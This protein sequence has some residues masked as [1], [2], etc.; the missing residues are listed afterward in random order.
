MKRLFL[1]VLCTAMLLQSIGCAAAAE[2]VTADGAENSAEEYVSAAEESVTEDSF[3]PIAG[4]A[5]E[6]NTLLAE[7]AEA[8]ERVINPKT[9]LYA[10]DCNTAGEYGFL[11]TDNVNALKGYNTEKGSVL[12]LSALSGGEYGAISYETGSV[13]DVWDGTS[14]TSWYGDGTADSY[15]ITSAAALAGLSKLVSGGSSMEGKRFI[16]QCNVDLDNKE[17]TPIGGSN[18]KFKGVFDGNGN[19]IRNLK[20]TKSSGGGNIGVFGY[21]EGSL[22]RLGVN[23]AEVSVSSSNTGKITMAALVGYMTG[24]IENCYAVNASLRLLRTDSKESSRVLDLIAPVA[25]A[26]GKGTAMNYCY[27]DNLYIYSSWGA[28]TGGIFGLSFGESSAKTAINNCYTGGSCVIETNPLTGNAV[29]YYPMGAKNTSANTSG[30]K[31]MCGHTTGLFKGD[32]ETYGNVYSELAANTVTAEELKQ[33]AAALG[34]A[35]KTDIY[36]INSGLPI[37]KSQ[38]TPIDSSLNIAFDLNVPQTAG[39]EI[40][41]YSGKDE[42]AAAELGS[43]AADEWKEIIIELCD[44]KYRIL[45]DGDMKAE[46]SLSGSSGI[47]S[48]FALRVRGEDVL[49]DNI[50]IYRDET[51]SLIQKAEALKGQIMTQAPD[52]PVLNDDILLPSGE[53]G[54]II[55]WKSENT[56]VLSD[57][58]S[59]KERKNCSVPVSMTAEIKLPYPDDKYAAASIEVVFP[60]QIAPNTGASDAEK[61]A[62]ILDILSNGTCI[63]DEPWNKISKN[64][65]NLPA[66]WDGASIAWSTSDADV[67][68]NDGTVH[69]KERQSGNAKLSAAVTLGD[70]SESRDFDFTV[71]SADTMLREAADAVTYMTLTDEEW[72]KITKDLSLPENGLYDTQITWSSDRPS[73]LTDKGYV[74]EIPDDTAV[75]LT[76][77]FE[78]AGYTRTKEFPFVLRLSAGKKIEADIAEIN[79]PVSVDDDF[80]VPLTGLVYESEITWSS[81]SEYLE[82]DGTMI[83]VTRPENETGNVEASLTASFSNSGM[84]VNREYT[85]TVVCLPPDDALL[86]EV[87]DGVSFSDISYE[88]DLTAIMQDLHLVNTF[89]YGISASWSSDK[90]EIVSADGKVTRPA[91]GSADEEVVL[92]LTL[93]RGS[94][95]KSKTFRFTV[96]AYGTPE[97]ILSAAAEQLTFRKLSTEPIDLVSEDL[98]LPKAWSYGTEISWQSDS[99]LLAI[100]ENDDGGYRGKVTRPAFASDNKPVTLTATL[101]YSGMTLKKEF[102]ITLAESNG[103]VAVVYEDFDSFTAGSSFTESVDGKTT[104]KNKNQI[105]TIAADPADRTNKVMKIEKTTDLPWVSSGSDATINS[106]I[107]TLSRSGDFRVSFKLFIERMSNLRFRITMPFVGEGLEEIDIFIESDGTV[108]QKNT[109]NK[110]SRKLEIGSWNDVSIVFST[111]SNTLDIYLG[112]ECILKNAPFAYSTGSTEVSAVKMKFVPPVGSSDGTAQETHTVYVDDLKVLRMVDYASEMAEAMK[113]L[114]LGFLAAQNINA[115]TKDI[116]IPDISRYAV[117]V[118]TTSSNTQIVE[119]NGTVHRGSSDYEVAYTVTLKNEYGGTRSRTFK[120]LVK[121]ANYISDDEG[122]TTD[123]AVAVL[124]DAKQAIKL[125]ESN[126]NLGY[127]TGNLTLPSVGV[128][129]STLSWKSTNPAVLSDSG[130]VTRQ[131]TDTKVTIYLTAT[132]GSVSERIETEL[133]IK[134]AAGSNTPQGGG[135]GGG[136]G[137]SGGKGGST[138]IAPYV[139]AEDRNNQDSEPQT[140][141]VF[142]DTEGHWAKEAVLKLYEMGIVNGISSTEF[143]T[144]NAVTREEFVTMLVRLLGYEYSGS[145]TVRFT[146]VK[147]DDWYY[148]Y[149]MAAYDAG[150][151]EGMSETRFGAGENISRQDLCVMLERALQKLGISADGTNDR[152]AD[153]DSISDYAR[154]A[155]H[156]LKKLEIIGGKE[157]NIFDPR[158]AATRAEAAKLIAGLTEHTGGE[159]NTPG[160]GE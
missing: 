139:P 140:Q 81:S 48:A 29:R 5:A 7:P 23:G 51:E 2:D 125:L 102:Y 84:V 68:E 18:S 43:Y 64:L 100:E 15:E 22:L 41:L 61:V 89:R 77:S 108:Y 53:D 110:A 160:E 113:Q 72:Q 13:T 6:E 134:A 39:A 56:E 76:A 8:S 112:D 157:N 127:I 95:V 93:T 62:D 126:Y 103:D 123:Q 12:N 99:P 17:W 52:F 109:G 155:V 28:L 71:L 128:N 97:E 159:E 150:I 9:V 156:V 98:I 149:V 130:A 142:K 146:D 121:K 82:P 63:T 91:I 106:L 116:I 131:S 104:H 115:I 120:L 33:G 1:L 26:L 16:L 44:G 42:A 96:A 67:I 83:R 57:A 66:E 60:F 114:E 59:I 147:A 90:P 25:G 55:T 32:K 50:M 58:G 40:V 75:T 111:Y 124:Y 47:V 85:V 135:G 94:T 37:L 11:S 30:S 88:T 24:T 107:P 136:G 87:L 4:T 137:I 20:I 154:Q 45:S 34:D 69:I 153:E 152:F 105:T 3:I 145:E 19:E 144:E 27:S 151:V 78:K 49:L 129:G 35:Y 80:S 118:S 21:I 143:G 36:Y 46:G 119:D 138:V 10:N 54:C 117:T 92:T 74:M 122:G 141:P 86:Q 158:G 101:S 31:N 14:D 70:V 148:R 133:T 73:L 79:L 65:A 132:L 38:R